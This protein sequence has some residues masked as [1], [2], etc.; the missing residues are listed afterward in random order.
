MVRWFGTWFNVECDVIWMNSLKPSDMVDRFMLFT[1]QLW[2]A[3]CFVDDDEDEEK[4]KR[5]RALGRVRRLMVTWELWED[6]MQSRQRHVLFGGSAEGDDEVVEGELVA[7]E[8]LEEVVLIMVQDVRDQNGKLLIDDRQVTVE[9]AEEVW[10]VRNLG[11]MEEGKEKVE[12]SLRSMNGGVKFDFRL[13]QKGDDGLGGARDIRTLTR[14]DRRFLR[15]REEVNDEEQAHEERTVTL[16]A[17]MN[18]QL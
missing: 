2:D 6:A 8:A 15:W 17:L 9:D 4:A 11:L 13:I 14:H 5:W 16:T 1:K 7:L 10:G 18:L 3:S 12:R